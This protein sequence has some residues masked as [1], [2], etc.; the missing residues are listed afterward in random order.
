MRVFQ[1]AGV[2]ASKAT[3]WN[4]YMWETTTLPVTFHQR[5]FADTCTFDLDIRQ[6]AYKG[7]R[8]TGDACPSG[9]RW[10]DTLFPMVFVM[11]L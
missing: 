9:V 8:V 6:F 1:R 2:C 11:D 7:A 3:K 5:L 4:A 10:E